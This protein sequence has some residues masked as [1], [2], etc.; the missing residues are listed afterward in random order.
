MTRRGG[1]T[2][3]A[4]KAYIL[5]CSKIVPKLTQLQIAQKVNDKFGR[6]VR[7]STISRILHGDFSHL[8]TQKTS[9]YR[10]AES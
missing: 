8:E 2:T 10:K 9:E 6:P 1:D 7:Q 3:D 4:M 5:R